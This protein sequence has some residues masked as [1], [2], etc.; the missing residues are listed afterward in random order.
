MKERN[1]AQNEESRQIEESIALFTDVCKGRWYAPELKT[2]T[3]SEFI[4][5]KKGQPLG[6]YPSFALFGLTHNML[7]QTIANRYH[8]PNCF[9]IVGDDIIIT[10]PKVA[11]VYREMMTILGCEISPL[12]TVESN[13]LTEFAGKVIT[14]DRVVQVHKWKPFSEKNIFGP[15]ECLGIKGI[16]FVPHKHRKFVKHA[17]SLPK[18][19]GL[20]QN[21]L[22]I[23][24]EY[25]VEALNHKLWKKLHDGPVTDYCLSHDDLANQNEIWWQDNVM[26]IDGRS[27]YSESIYKHILPTFDDQSKVDVETIDIEH[28]NAYIRSLKNWDFPVLDKPISNHSVKRGDPREKIYPSFTNSLYKYVRILKERIA[29]P[30]NESKPIRF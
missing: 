22:G 5:W 1:H 29:Q 23:P 11:R 8:A 28:Y 2:E 18:P 17:A 16:A 21:P 4:S 6:L 19:F 12:K 15:L 20:E 24:L 14:Q 30:V 3:G 10:H 13:K 25:R 27:Y 26:C 9:R 7:V